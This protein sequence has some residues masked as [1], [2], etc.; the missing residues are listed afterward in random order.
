MKDTQEH[1]VSETAVKELPAPQG[2]GMAVAVDW[3]LSA[4]ILL[5][6]ILSTLLGR[7]NP[8]KVPGVNST[9]STVLSLLIAL[10]VACIPAFFGEMIRSGRNWALKVQIALNILLSIAG[11]LSLIGVYQSLRAGE[12]RPLI[13]AFI[14]VIIAPLTVWR[15]TRP[16]TFQWFKLVTPAEARKRH[17]G[18]W[19]WFII[20][21][22]AIG[23][24]LQTFATLK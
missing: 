9:L 18:R 10:V 8:L 6:P 24:L 15:L 22:A 16:S 17:G 3:G 7:S 13:T 11:I 21:C 12:F 4:Q 20:L 2:I 5:T 19:V 14:L 23:G 1:V